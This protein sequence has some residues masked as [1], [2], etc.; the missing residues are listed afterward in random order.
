MGQAFLLKV[1]DGAELPKYYT[2]AGLRINEM[3]IAYGAVT[4]RAT[5]IMLGSTAENEIR[6]YALS[7]STPEC[8]LSFEDGSK[9]RGRLLFTRLDYGG[10]FN[11]ERN[12]ILEAASVGPMVPA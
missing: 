3:N 5:G 6:G 2:K 11:G 9:L 10:D 7:G 12:H 1:G 4:L 8:E